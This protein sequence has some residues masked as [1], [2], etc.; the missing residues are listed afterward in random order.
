MSKKWNNVLYSIIFN[1]R[2]VMNVISAPLS[3]YKSYML[4]NVAYISHC[5]L[6]NKSEIVS[7]GVSR[8]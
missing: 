6:A 7:G 4:I 8:K 5:A 1:N 3:F 2:G